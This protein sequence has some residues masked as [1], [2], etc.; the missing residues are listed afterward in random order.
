MLT[1][2]QVVEIKVM[3]QRGMSIR[4]MARQLGCSRNKVRRYMHEGV[5]LVYGPRS[6]RATKLNPFKGY[7]LQRIEAARPHCIPAVVAIP[8][9]NQSAQAWE[10]VLRQIGRQH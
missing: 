9:Q 3:S 8:Q 2:K 5:A 10:P 7:L 6:P 4:E 1:E